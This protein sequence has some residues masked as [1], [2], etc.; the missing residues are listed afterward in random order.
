MWTGQNPHISGLL[1]HGGCSGPCLPT[2]E[3]QGEDSHCHLGQICSVLGCHL[4]A[5]PGTENSGGPASWNKGRG[6]NQ[7]SSCGKLSSTIPK[8]SRAS[9]GPGRQASKHRAAVTRVV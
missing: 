3:Q 7:R 6:Q 2:G 4:P 5:H 8:P 1:E 9:Q